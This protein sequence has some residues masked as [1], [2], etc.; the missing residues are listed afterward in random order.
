MVAL[1]RKTLWREWQRFVPAVL[2]VGFAGLLLTV[3]AALVLGIFGSAA[4]YMKASSGDLWAG[5][6]G[7]QSVNLGRGINA[8]VEMALRM[9]P[10]VSAV[11][12]MQWLDADWRSGHQNGGVSIA[13]IGINPHADGMLFDHLLTPT[14]RQLLLQ[15]GAVIVD[16]ADLDQLATRVGDW[17]WI[18]SHQVAV[19]G[20]VAGLRALGGVNVLG[21]LDTV[22]S[23]NG[24]P[25]DRGHPTYLVARLRHP[26]LAAQVCDRLNRQ[27]TFGAHAV[28][29]TEAFSWRSQMFWMLDTGAGVAVLFLAAIVLVVGVVVAGQALTAVVIGSAREYATL[30]ALGAG[31][32]ALSWVVLE[33]SAWIG[34]VGLLIGG[35][36]S[37]S[38]LVIAASR[39][40]PV[41]MNTLAATVCA[42]L[43]LMLALVSG[44]VAMRGLLRADPALLLR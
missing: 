44:L 40:V 11:E 6:P 42:L 1:A 32:R 20:S 34:A 9:E 36:L 10:D 33:Q 4:V 27:T 14:Q 16:R 37:A 12:P 39:D 30:N 28:W 24:D 41:A 23:L 35:V 7:T 5:Y 21:S 18:N 31:R 3:Q 15:P 22:R 25:R 13:A 17:A 8:D 26:A 29:T 19:V 43:V 2:A 38:L